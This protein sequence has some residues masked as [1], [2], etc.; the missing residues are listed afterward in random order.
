MISEAQFSAIAERYRD[1]GA[2]AQW[3]K[4]LDV[5][6]ADHRRE[7]PNDPRSDREI[8]MSLL[9]EILGEPNP[10]GKWALPLIVDD[11]RPQL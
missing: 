6:L 8:F 5:M 2:V 9:T 1:R 7:E 10:D 3:A 4:L 11:H